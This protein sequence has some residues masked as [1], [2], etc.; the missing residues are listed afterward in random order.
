MLGTHLGTH[1]GAGFVKSTHSNPENCIYVARPASGTV[2]VKDGKEGATGA[3][4]EFSGDAW[5]SFVE[6]AKGLEV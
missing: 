3:T 5:A 4:L 1:R 2:G 6:F